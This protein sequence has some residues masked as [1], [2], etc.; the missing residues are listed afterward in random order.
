MPWH[1]HHLPLSRPA[2][3]AVAR[4]L[5]DRH[6]DDDPLALAGARVLLPATRACAELGGALIEA[7]ATPALLLPRAQ[8]PAGLAAELAGLQG[9]SLDGLPDAALRPLLLAPHLARLDWL[10]HRPQAAPGLAA[11]LIDLFDEV[12]LARCDALVLGGADDASLLA[13][14]DPAAA[15][16]LE[17]DLARLREVWACYRE[18]VPQDAVD[19]R[20]AA[21]AAAARRW[22]GAPPS[23]V[24]VAHPGRLDRATAAVLAALATAGTDVHLLVPEA[25]TPRARLLLAT[26]RDPSAPAHP[27]AGVR[28]LAGRLGAPVPPAPAFAGEH[29]AARL[30]HLADARAELAAGGPVTLLPCREPEHESRVIAH[31]VSEVLAAGAPVPRVLVATGDRDLAAR[32]TAQLR[33]AGIDV[34]DTRGRPLSGLP[35]GRLLRDLLRTAVAGWPY[36]PLFEVLGHPYV[37]LTADGERPGHGV[38]VQLLEAAVRRAGRARR[39]L[40]S[41]RAAAAADDAVAGEHRRGWSLADLVDRT[42]AALAPLVAVDGTSPWTEILAAIG[43]VWQAVAPGRPLGGAAEPAADHDDLGALDGLLADLE[44]LAPSLPPATLAEATAALAGLLAGIEVRP[45]RQRHLPVV[46]TGLVEA[47]L[48]D[49]EVLVLGGMGQD[50][51]PGSLPRPLLLDARVRAHLGLDHWRDRAGRDAELF[52]RLLHAAPRVLITW[53]QERGGQPALPSPLVQRLLLAAPSPPATAPEVAL[54]RRTVPDAATLAAPEEVFRAEPEPVP[55]PDVARPPRLSHSAMQRYRECPYRFLL[56]DALGLRR[57]DPLEPVFDA[58]DVGELAHAVMQTWLA[59]DGEAVAALAA[60]DDGH[61]HDLLRVAADAALAA[62]GR[63]VPGGAVAIRTLLDLAP[64]LVASE[65]ASLPQWRPAAVE[66]AFQVTLGQIAAWLGVHDEAPP[67]VP[68]AHADY[69][70]RGR[71]DRVD[72]ARDGTPRAVV[73]DYKTGHVPSKTRS[74]DGRELQ[75]VL[76][77]LAV[78]AGT[79]TGL[80]PTP[81]GWRLDRAG[82]YRLRAPDPGPSWHLEGS[83]Q[84]VPGARRI[85]EQAAAILDP[86]QPF[87]LVP[88]WQEEDA[89]GA[90]PCR[91]CE[92]AGICR[93]QERDTSPAL[94]ARVARLLAS[95]QGGRP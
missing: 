4:W 54:R 48:A 91:H 76:Y 58:A 23:L 39:G 51:F 71:I 31:Q 2:L 82:Y 52:L 92:F 57:P 29:L 16:V 25:E 7:A 9:R 30:D 80:P 70:L 13:A 74:R 33:D 61:A 56:A 87:A 24:A 17:H 95:D 60:G 35:A 49:V 81:D 34:D 14:T 44:E 66:A 69:P 3:P 15:G 10:A 22:P 37:R 84:L 38:R 89:T 43:A 42:A 11:E 47:R 77:G 93:L 75:V 19:V 53:P 59:P 5:L 68:D 63:D 32:V 21:L 78:E 20:V 26:Y 41:L 18:H 72:I 50:I 27:L 6:A 73:V 86:A 90:L 62:Q 67:T 83:Q 1:L 79:V 8:T 45:H 64:A 40:A 36:G 85:L 88:D 12:R 46:V 94:A 65:R 55:A 28:R